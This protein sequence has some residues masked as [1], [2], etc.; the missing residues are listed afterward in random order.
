MKQVVSLIKPRWW[1]F[2]KNGM[3][4][5]N[6]MRL[7]IF[8]GI[9]LGF[10][11]G[12][13]AVTYRVLVYFQSVEGFGDVLAK[14]LL[15]M[16]ILTFFSLLVFSA[17]L[18]TLSKLYLSRDLDLVHSMPVSSETIFMARWIEST[19]DSSWMVMVYT[20]PIFLSYAL[21]YRTGPI[22]YLDI[23][24]VLLPLCIVA[25]ALSAMVV[26]LAVIILPASRVRSIF[27]FL[28]LALLIL[29]YMTFRMLRPERL[30]DPEAF[31]TVMAYLQT[32]NTPASPWLPSTWA[33]D[34]LRAALENR[35]KDAFF[36]AALSWS[37]A[38]FLMAVNVQMARLTYFSG[39]SKTQAAMI[40]L[41][42]SRD[43]RLYRILAPLS[44]PTRAFVFKEIRSFWR[45]QTQWSQIFLVAALVAI[46]LYN[47]SVLPLDKSPIRTVYLQNLF[48]FLNMALAAFV[49]TAVTA[50]F[51]FPSVSIEG[52]SFWIVRSGPISIRRFLWIKFFI[53]LLP[54]LVLSQVL[55]VA[56]NLL[57]HVTPFMMVLSVVT[58]F[59]LTP[60][61]ISMGVGLGA[62]YPD[63]GSENP[64]QTVTSF[65]GLIFMILSAAF[66][67]AVT[68][69]Q[70]G[71]V[72]TIFMADLHGRAISMLQWTWII[73][74]FALALVLSILALVL[75][76][77]FGIRRLSI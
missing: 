64:A 46:Y 22:F 32:L 8:G 50:R 40:R 68:I 16:V 61:V 27:V 30:V 31:S 15:S 29:L 21:V 39:F 24:L 42:Q 6:K 3:G 36:N 10:W 76:M 35:P 53:Y 55:I 47:F 63:F 54:L 45:D 49:L 56:T 44:G 66:I 67:G 2:A 41:F 18:T 5:G 19:V 23:F 75:P 12:I 57:L 77:R 17:I 9:G 13:F 1:T 62:A 74:S 28:G 65:G 43:N 33:Y 14:K 26:M 25:S 7:A 52:F 34:S 20:I 69:L 71:P 58:M 70:A 37:C 60:G 51:A 59:F 73:V 4:T 48:S 72:Y 38:G 11:A